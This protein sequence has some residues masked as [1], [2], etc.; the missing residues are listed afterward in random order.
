MKHFADDA[1]E[2]NV[3]ELGRIRKRFKLKPRA[4][5][6]LHLRSPPPQFSNREI[7][8]MQEEIRPGPPRE[9]NYAQGIQI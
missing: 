7:E 9:H 2:K 3:D 8:K 1:F 6:T 5:P 4:R